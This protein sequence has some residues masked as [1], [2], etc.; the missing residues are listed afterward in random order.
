[1]NNDTKIIVDGK[2]KTIKQYVNERFVYLH[3]LKAHKYSEYWEAKEKYKLNNEPT[4]SEGWYINYWMNTQVA[5]IQTKASEVLNSTPRYDFIAL[6]DKSRRNKRLREYFWD[7]IWLV[8]KTDSAILAIAFDAFKYWVWF[9]KEVYHI[10]KR[11]IQEPKISNDW[12]DFDEKEVVEYEGCKLFHLPWNTVWVNG[13]N[14]EETTEAIIV[15]NYDRAKFFSKFKLNPMYSNISEESIPC[16]RHYYVNEWTSTLTIEWVATSTAEWEN[17][18]DSNNIVSVLEYYNKYR[19]EYIVMANGVW[20][21][22]YKGKV[23]PNPTISKEI[24]IV[25]YT[26]I[27]IEDDIYSIGDY[28]LSKKSSALKDEARSLAIE[29]VKAQ[30]WIIT[31]DPDS[32]FDEA[33]MELGI[34]KYARVKR[35][36]VGFFAPN[37][38]ASTLQYIEAKADEDII[39][40]TW[41]DF[42]SQLLNPNETAT[43]TAGRINSWKNRINLMIK[44]NAYTF[45]ER[46]ARLRMSNMEFYWEKPQIMVTKWIEI[47]EDG[48]TK[49]L[50]GWYG[51]FT[52]KPEYFSWKL[53]LIPNIDSFT[54]NTTTENKQ[55]YLETAQLLLNIPSKDGGMLFDPM[56]IIEAGRGV[57]D[58]VI[59]IDKLSEKTPT[60][61]KAEDI[62][63]E[64]DS[65]DNWMQSNMSWMPQDYVPPEQRSWKAMI[66]PSS[67]NQ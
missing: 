50:N 44:Y 11:I 66:L 51:I 62:L 38:N 34:R 42:R 59:D 8:S 46:L 40:E 49:P 26:N 7:Y 43:K 12:I 4:T 64:V 48:N 53:S 57:I 2:E 14:M 13:R 58:E 41:I 27:F 18:V 1:M 31:I 63:N 55:K 54:W 37:I 29:V 36:E 65:I 25:C 32:E 22:P 5:I 19:D 33:V 16:N 61:K 17:W 67:P 21:N 35:D 47:S 15:T 39:V 9:W 56:K 24:P 28:K 10:E 3:S 30:G 45:Y 60:H 20:I 23:M 6:D 52:M